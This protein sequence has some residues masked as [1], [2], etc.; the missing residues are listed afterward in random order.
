[1]IIIAQ[2]QDI[3]ERKRVEETLRR[4]EEKFKKA[5]FTSPDSVSI[6]RLRDGM[7]VS[8]NKGFTQISGYT[9]EETVGKTSLEIN[10]WK[11]P[12]DRRK[13]VEELLAKGEVRDYEVS[14]LT[15]NHE[16]FSDDPSFILSRFSSKASPAGVA[17]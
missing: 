17:L 16:L 12:E 15:K 9:E 7:F 6:N 14:F 1:V 10:I 11:Y 3:T 2:G 4:S 8:I 5:F 13:I